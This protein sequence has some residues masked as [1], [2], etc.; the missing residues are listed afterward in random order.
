MEPYISKTMRRCNLLQSEIET[1]YHEAAKKFGI[2]DSTLIILYTLCMFGQSCPLSEI[3]RLS[4]LR[5]QTVNSALR[6]MERDGLISLAASGIKTKDV[7]LTEKG[8]A[9][10][11]KTALPLLQAEDAIFLSWEEQD[12]EQYL[13]LT[14]RFLE[15]L[16]EKIE[17]LSGENYEHG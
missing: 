14:A 12:V 3:I 15:G 10:A 11:E 5:K 16:K 2:S 17:T 6:N 7:C 9:L 13:T 1:V 4:G 8:E